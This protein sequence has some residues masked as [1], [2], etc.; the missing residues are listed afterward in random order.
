MEGHHQFKDVQKRDEVL[1]KLAELA[2]S[3]PSEMSQAVRRLNERLHKLVAIQT[4]EARRGVRRRLV[5][6]EVARRLVL[7]EL[8]GPPQLLSDSDLTSDG[9]LPDGFNPCCLGVHGPIPKWMK[10]CYELSGQ[11]DHDWVS[12]FP[13]YLG[14]ARNLHRGTFGD[15][16]FP[17]PVDLSQV[18]AAEMWML[19]ETRPLSRQGKASRPNSTRARAEVDVDEDVAAAY[20]A[21]YVGALADIAYGY[22][23][24]FELPITTE[25]AS[26]IVLVTLLILAPNFDASAAGVV[27]MPR[28]ETAGDAR[29]WRARSFTFLVW[30]DR[31]SDIEILC[32]LAYRALTTLDPKCMVLG[33]IPLSD[34]DIDDLLRRMSTREEFVSKVRHITQSNVPPVGW[35]RN[36]L[37]KL[38]DVAVK[39]IGRIRE[40]TKL[41]K[42]AKSQRDVVY[43]PPQLEEMA[44]AA[45]RYASGKRTWLR[46][47]ACF[48]EALKECG[49]RTA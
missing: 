47:A 28:W 34:D 13:R 15:W 25:K 43:M 48:E 16:E 31:S 37:A 40:R 20:H 22:L 17:R 39:T 24:E 26:D 33:A 29:W 4:R 27:G 3:R 30:Q 14:Y 18:T 11:F 5:M 36:D 6:L 12:D 8:E 44:D 49:Y 23:D 1:A 41:P 46:A 38:A 7:E 10:L 35:T 19:H 32:K 2:T 9:P 21:D 45:R 42:L